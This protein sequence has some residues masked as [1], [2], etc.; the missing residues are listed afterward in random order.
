MFLSAVTDINY[1]ILGTPFFEKYIQNNI[2]QDF[3]MNFKHSVKDQP[4]IASFTTLFEKEFPF[5]FSYLSFNFK[6]GDIY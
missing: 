5:L 2:I 1:I 3:T 4:I 6:K